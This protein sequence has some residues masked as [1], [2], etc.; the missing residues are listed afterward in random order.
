MKPQHLETN[1]DISSENTQ[2]VQKKK[3]IDW[4][5]TIFLTTTPIVAIALSALYFM[6][7]GLQWS[8]I[9]LAVIFYFATGLS[10]TGGYHRLFSHR[11]YKA[12]NLVKFL[13]LIFGAAT[14]QNSALKWSA[15]HRIHHTH[16]DDEK[17]PYNINKGFWWAHIGWI[18]FQEKEVEPKYP[19]DL[20]NDKLVMWQ[21][22]NYLWLA[23]VMGVILPTVIGYFLG[24]ALGGLALAGFGRI[25]FVHHC[26]FFI[27]S[28]CHIV[29]T[30]PYTD[31]NTARDSAIMAVFSYGEGYHNYHHYF[32][33]DYRNGIKWYH[34]DPTK[35]MIKTLS[36]VGWTS[37]LKKVQEK[38]IT[39]AKLEME[40]KKYQPAA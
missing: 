32:P 14:F 4:V 28:L 11:A 23:V 33:V 25:V 36:F 15:D 29:G 16:V 5:N 27:N 2:P 21:H 1:L 17:D 13:Y 9:A 38:L 40:M 24:S 3:Q 6:Q 10:I 35:W 39:Q 26:T 22:R 12:N 30:R 31:T 20:L 37:D 18:F 34:F 7:N 19:K 8:Q